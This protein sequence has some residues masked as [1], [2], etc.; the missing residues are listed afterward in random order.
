MTPA[1]I[2]MMDPPWPEKGGGNRGADAHY[3]LVPYSDIFRVVA[4][5]RWP[6]GSLV[7]DPDPEGC[8]VACWTTALSKKYVPGLFSRLGVRET[9]HEW[10]WGKSLDE[11]E[12]YQIG[13]GQWGRTVHEYLVFGKVGKLHPSHLKE[14]WPTIFHAPRTTHSE[15]PPVAYE[16]IRAMLDGPAV[17]MF[18]RD[19]RPGFRVWGDEAPEN[20]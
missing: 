3:D 11:G 8:L 18:E 6:D 20:P 4:S 5:A 12:T 14:K 16:R 15:K 17:A 7:F 19:H 9:G 10:I 1:R 13:M 2:I